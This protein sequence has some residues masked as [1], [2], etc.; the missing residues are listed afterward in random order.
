[1]LLI[2]LPMEITML[3]AVAMIFI[4]GNF[5]LPLLPI[6]MAVVLLITQYPRGSAMNKP[7]GNSDDPSTYEEPA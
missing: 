4:T 1:M 7:V 3:A 2:W 5:I 6:G